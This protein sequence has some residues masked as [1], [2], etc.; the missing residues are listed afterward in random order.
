M[1]APKR[2]FVKN[3]SGETELTGDGFRHA[4]N[5]LRLSEGDEVTVFDGGG[6]EYAA[7]I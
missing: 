6:A 5:V 3:I 2:F 4:K 1:S 7:I